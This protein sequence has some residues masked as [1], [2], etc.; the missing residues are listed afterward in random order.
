[1]HAKINDGGAA[2]T[3]ALPGRH[4]G[5]GVVEALDAAA[6]GQRRRLAEAEFSN[7]FSTPAYLQTHFVAVAI[8]F[9]G[10]RGEGPCD[11]DG[12]C[13]GEAEPADQR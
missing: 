5:R 13:H 12:P 11:G 4:H 10:G 9:V 7:Q 8:C 6:E 1:M 3:H 2:V